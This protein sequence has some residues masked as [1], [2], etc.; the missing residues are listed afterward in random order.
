MV[1]PLLYSL[2]YANMLLNGTLNDPL[3]NSDQLDQSNP[4]TVFLALNH[5]PPQQ[6]SA[7]NFRTFA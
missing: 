5:N 2:F 4:R 7:P 1:N 3:G 6:P